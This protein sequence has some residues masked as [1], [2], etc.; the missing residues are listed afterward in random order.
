MGETRFWLYDS[1]GNRLSDVDSGT[2]KLFLSQVGDTTGSTVWAAFDSAGG[3]TW[4]AVHPDTSDIFKVCYASTLHAYCL[5]DSLPWWGIYVPKASIHSHAFTAA[6]VPESALMEGII[7]PRHMDTDSSFVLALDTLSTI[8]VSVFPNDLLWESEFR[9]WWTA[10]AEDSL[11][12][13][14]YDADFDSLVAA[15]CSL[16]V[17]TFDSVHA[18]TVV[19]DSALT[20][21]AYTLPITD[22]TA[23]QILKT[24]GSGVATWQADVTGAGGA[25]YADSLRLGGTTYDADRWF[26]TALLDTA[27]THDA[28]WQAYI[29]A[30]QTSAYLLLT[31]WPDSIAVTASTEL[32]DTADILY[33]AELDAFSELQTQIGD[34][35]LVNEED[36]CTIDADWVNTANPWAVNE[37]HGDLLTATE[38]NAAYLALA[39][40]AD[41]IAVTASTELTDTAEILYE[42]ELNTFAEL[43]TQIADKVLVNTADAANM[44][45]ATVT[46][47]VDMGGA[48][49][50]EIPNGTDPDL[51]V[52]GQISNDTDGANL[53]G[54]VIVRGT[55]GTNQWPVGQKIVR[56]AAVNVIKPNDLADAE[57]DKC[58]IGANRSGMTFT[59]TEIWAISDL[60]AADLMIEE[61]DADGASNQS[62]VDAIQ[63]ATGTGPYTDTETTITAG[64]IENGHTL[65]SDFD[66][67]DAPGYVGIVVMGWYNADVN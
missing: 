66:D 48:T 45:L 49:S 53:T 24:D 65:W 17:A 40:F 27:N 43:Q 8:H 64:V 4:V 67:A 44:V 50:F 33:E 25:D 26:T 62:N 41:S 7:C 37:V 16:A 38:G 42:T 35:T 39:A 52:A 5:L 23:N 56:F 21:G 1:T 30:R 10:V 29:Q 28:Q 47:T 57:R 11:D 46:G 6:C 20:I 31:S 36:V 2:V 3:S 55:D 59:I 60:S 63:C 19:I 14:L 34:K 32:S 58:F 12:A 61:Y 9:A 54:D 15:W 13:G 18:D 22:G 51:T